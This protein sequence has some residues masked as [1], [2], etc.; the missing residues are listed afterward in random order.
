[1]SVRA[2]I[3]EFGGAASTSKPNNGLEST[4]RNATS[5]SGAGS[6]GQYFANYSTPTASGDV[7]RKVKVPDTFK[8][9]SKPAGV[10]AAATTG[11]AA[12]FGGSAPVGKWGGAGAGPESKAPTEAPLSGTASRTT[13][14]KVS[15]D[16]RKPRDLLGLA[17]ATNTGSS[18]TLVR[19]AAVVSEPSAASG[20]GA[21]RISGND[22]GRASPPSRSHKPRAGPRKLNLTRISAEKQRAALCLDKDLDK[23]DRDDPAANG[24]GN[25]NGG[26]RA[27]I[28]VGGAK[29]A[30]SS[31][32]VRSS[33]APQ[34]STSHKRS[35]PVPRAGSQ[36]TMIGS[37]MAESG[38]G[39]A[40]MPS[41]SSLR[42][43]G[44][45]LW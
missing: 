14:S 42:P 4:T 29:P 9:A 26:V 44:H 6:N 23:E 21:R 25:G 7:A 22:V 13:K 16:A 33:E 32:S 3:A 8:N 18:S 11:L 5:V 30:S 20:N 43:S 27:G 31:S 40:V 36:R 15:S 10:P 12:S 38:G 37:S 35:A 17:S 39:G 34:P 24:N 2:K 1:M 19:P 41:T 28:S 45:N